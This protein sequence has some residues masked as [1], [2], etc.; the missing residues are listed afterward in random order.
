MH[1]QMYV[2]QKQASKR[3]HKHTN[4]NTHTNNYWFSCNRELSAPRMSGVSLKIACALLNAPLI[5]PML[6]RYLYRVRINAHTLSFQYFLWPRFKFSIKFHSS[7]SRKLPCLMFCRTFM[8]KTMEIPEKPY[9]MWHTPFLLLDQIS[10][11]CGY[12][13]FVDQVGLH[14]KKMN[15]C[16]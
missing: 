5:S 3:R 10:L 15:I 12:R 11:F 2:T 4:A 6:L 7:K 1:T 13:L 8:N 16:K 14:L 9:K